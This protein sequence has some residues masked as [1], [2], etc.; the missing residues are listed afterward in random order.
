MPV[1]G[2][3]PDDRE[4]PDHIRHNLESI[5]PGYDPTDKP[6]RC[7]QINTDYIS[8]LL[9]GIDYFV[10]PDAFA[11]SLAERELAASRMVA[12]Q[13]L[14]MTGNVDCGELDNM[15]LRQNPDNPC[16]LEQSFDNGASWSLAFDY[17]LCLRG[18]SFPDQVA[19]SNNI[20]TAIAV[21]NASVD[22]WTGDWNDVAPGMEFDLSSDDDLR[23]QAYCFAV[24]LMLVQLADA[25]SYMEREGWSV[26]QITDVVAEITKR[27]AD[28]LLAILNVTGITT[29]PR[30]YV[31]V[32]LAKI[33]AGVVQEFVE[34]IDDAPE[35]VGFVD[36]SDQ[37][38]LLCC[39][40]ENIRGMTPSQLRFS[41]MFDSCGTVVLEPIVQAC[42]TELMSSTEYYIA[43]LQL[44]E[45]TFQAIEDGQR[46]A[47]PCGVE[48]MTF[49]LTTESGVAPDTRYGL[50]N[51][52]NPVYNEGCFAYVAESGIIQQP[53]STGDYTSHNGVSMAL[54]GISGTIYSVRVECDYAYGVTEAMDIVAEIVYGGDR[55]RWEPVEFGVGGSKSIIRTATREMSNDELHIGVYCGVRYGLTPAWFGVVKVK[56]VIIQGE[57]LSFA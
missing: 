7:Y 56:R 45:L 16:Q 37:E 15:R 30:V 57:N 5:P 47:C 18:A 10:H 44:I 27:G 55:K 34:L 29:D 31:A 48:S 46:F 19:I 9:A 39:A 13:V 2:F 4:N 1:K 20:A 17:D 8:F 3:L 52:Y 41:T 21:A 49:E 6:V 32:Q 26:W 54:D 51:W 53:E 25:L 43:F 42:V 38:L 28:I 23:N 33:V 24:Q 22:V 35:I 11:G 36:G 12:L 40:M 14:L 50:D